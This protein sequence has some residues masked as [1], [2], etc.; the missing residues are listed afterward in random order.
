VCLH[1]DGTQIPLALRCARRLTLPS[2][3]A[4]GE[5]DRDLAKMALALLLQKRPEARGEPTASCSAPL[6]GEIQTFTAAP[7]DANGT[8]RTDAN[9]TTKP[10]CADAA[11]A[12]TPYLLECS[13]GGPRREASR[14]PAAML[15]YPQQRDEVGEANPMSV[16]TAT[17]SQIVRMRNVTPGGRLYFLY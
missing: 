12:T 1:A 8:S 5:S 10:A 14:P 6:Y 2:S 7:R 9:G 16:I 3:A 15:H 4:G 11:S 17:G 13:R